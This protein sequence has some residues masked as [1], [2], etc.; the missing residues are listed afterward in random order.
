MPFIKGEKLDKLYKVLDNERNAFTYFR[1]PSQAAK[2]KMVYSKIH[3]VG[4]YILLPIATVFG[5]LFLNDASPIKQNI[6]EPYSEVIDTILKVE[7]KPDLINVQAL[8]ENV[9]VYSVQIEANTGK[10]QLLFSENFVNFS[11]HE[12]GKLNAYSIGSFATED[13]ANAFHNKIIDL[14]I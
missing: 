11:V 6:K 9:R 7:E 5:I 14:G 4:F 3:A 10:S 12:V 2:K 8:L 13:E 1:D